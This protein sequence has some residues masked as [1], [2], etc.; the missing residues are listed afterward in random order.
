M[1]ATDAGDRRALY[2]IRFGR[3]AEGTF[4]WI[5]NGEAE[6][7]QQESLAGGG[8][9]VATIEAG[10]AAGG[11]KSADEV[12]EAAP[13]GPVARFADLLDDADVD[14]G[15]CLRLLGQLTDAETYLVGK[16]TTLL[17]RMGRAF[18]GAEMTRALDLLRFL[19]LSDALQFIDSSNE[20]GAI[21]K[22][23]YQTI[24]N[25]SSVIDSFAAVVSARN[26]QILHDHSQVDPLSLPVAGN[27]AFMQQVLM[28]NPGFARWVLGFRGSD[29]GGA[30][31]LLRHL[32]A[33]SPAMT[34]AALRVSGMESE[35]LD[36]LPT[37][38]AL[39]APDQAAI[40][41]VFL[42]V[43]DEPGKSALMKKR[44]NFD[45]I[46]EDKNYPGAGT[47]EPA[48]L[49][50]M[51]SSS[52]ACPR[53][54]WRTTTGSRTSRGRTAGRRPA[55]APAATAWPSATARAPG[56]PRA[57]RSPI[58]ATSCAASTCSTRT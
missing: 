55:A 40:K 48:V 4:D 26:C 12:A 7:K 13:K 36:A 31:A 44:F 58:R 47:F 41:A 52:S 6:W 11:P 43:P 22:P 34:Y 9:T 37:G 39:P 54:T 2:E 53:A 46:R 16:D 42:A 18:D 32:A 27:D 19:P 51:W 25:R 23:T 8:Q 38:T 50:D 24:V 21:A 3:R 56:P 33:H 28:F 45:R 1:A 49:D 15:Q 17:Y 29:G 30:Q 10:I 20:E 5:A 14:E 35:F 57:A